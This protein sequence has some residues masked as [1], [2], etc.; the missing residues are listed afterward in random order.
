[1]ADIATDKAPLKAGNPR[2]GERLRI[3]WINCRLLHPLNGGDRIRTYNMLRELKRRHH[4]TYLCL[5]TPADTDEAVTKAA[6]FCDEVIAV[7][8]PQTSTKS[9]KFFAGLLKN[10]L[11]GKYPYI[12]EKYRSPETM[13]RIRQLSAQG[14]FDLIICDYLA[15]MINL[16]ELGERPTV[17]LIVF[18]HN[19]ESLIWKRHVET[20]TNPLKR[21]VYRKEWALTHQFED[22]SAAF[23]DGQITVSDDEYRYF[24]N[25][26][27]MSNVI[28]AVPTGVD[29]EYYQPSDKP[30]PHTMAFLGSMDWHANIDS[31]Q[32]FIREIY[33]KI[34]NR[35]PSARFLAIGRNPPASI[36]ALGEADPSIE[37][38]GTVPDVRPYLSRASVMVLPLRVG[39]GTRIKVFEAMAAGLTVV[40]TRVG[41]EGLPVTDR[42]NIVY[43]EKAGEFAERV[44]ELFAN[45]ALLKQIGRNGLDL[46]RQKFS[47][48]AAVDIFEQ[49]CFQVLQKK[50]RS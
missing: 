32:F 11:A 7:P 13:A 29:C 33:S 15:P 22:T 38:T 28:G 12:G 4:I 30:E 10:V 23:V 42:E 27:R 35:F 50:G 21:F 6:E 34:K 2:S 44:G 43:A 49:H 25:E 48:G 24:K 31:V 17:P 14:K 8:H 5:R 16:L 39:G 20:T 19:I 3:L 26:R 1:V 47:W 18:Q 45:P 40:S 36:R 9:F 41:A 46:V 37:I